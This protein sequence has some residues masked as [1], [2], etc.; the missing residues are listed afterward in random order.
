MGTH[1][2]IPFIELRNTIKHN[3]YN[4]KRGH[5]KIEILDFIVKELLFLGWKT[6]YDYD[7]IDNS[8]CKTDI[9]FRLENE[10]NELFFVDMNTGEK[11]K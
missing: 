6:V 8:N 1:S 3:E 10:V 9:Y 2:T 11:I 5:S 7:K 4:L